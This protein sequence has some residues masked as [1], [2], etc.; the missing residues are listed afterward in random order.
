MSEENEKLPP[1]F[2]YNAAYD[3]SRLVRL[4]YNRGVIALLVMFFMGI[5]LLVILA[6]D[7]ESAEN[8]TLFVSEILEGV[9]RLIP[10]RG[11]E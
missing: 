9:G 10:G 7:Q 8:M 5:L 4:M 6:Q 2:P 1:E 11:G 3:K